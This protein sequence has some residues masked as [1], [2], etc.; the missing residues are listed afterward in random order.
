VNTVDIAR[1]HLLAASSDI[2]EGVYN[3]ASGTETSLADLAR[4]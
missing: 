3:V 2:Q 4:A 1:A